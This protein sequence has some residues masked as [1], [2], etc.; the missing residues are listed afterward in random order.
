[1]LG[2]AAVAAAG[3][4]AAGVYGAVAP[5]SG[6]FGP[7]IGRGPRESSLYL[8][9]DDGPHAEWTPRILDILQHHHIPAVFFAVG[10]YAVAHPDIVRAISAD[11]HL[12]GN[13]TWS[14]RKLHLRSRP[15]IASELRRTHD[16]LAS[17]VAAPRA[18]RAPHGY[19]N[20]FVSNVTRA[21]GYTTFGWTFGVWDTARPGTEVIRERMKKRL[22]PGAILLLHDG[23]GRDPHSDRSQTVAAL[24]GIIEDAVARGYTFRPLSDLL[25]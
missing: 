16:A 15:Y 21:M 10:R 5:N 1:M 3:V 14:H 6:L 24:P 9:F 7:V 18:F 19:R 13:H 22:Q 12:L 8:T 2:A 25:P 23:D 20:P 11:G 17:I 4:A